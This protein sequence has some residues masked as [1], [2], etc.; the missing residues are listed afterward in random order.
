[1]GRLK[2]MDR[3]L[4]TVVGNIQYDLL[5]CCLKVHI[6]MSIFNLLEFKNNDELDNIPSKKKKKKFCTRFHHKGFMRFLKP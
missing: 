3:N 6:E 4:K 2:K 5:F 1:M